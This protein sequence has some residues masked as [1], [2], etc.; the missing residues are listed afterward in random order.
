MYHFKP[1]IQGGDGP[2]ATA[3]YTGLSVGPHVE[4]ADTSIL[5][6][7]VPPVPCWFK[8]EGSHN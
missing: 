7:E 8:E 6:L 4:R 2:R 1:E 3:A 5:E